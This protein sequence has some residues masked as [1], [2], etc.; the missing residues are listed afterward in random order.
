MNTSARIEELRQ[1]MISLG[2]S[3]GLSCPEVVAISE[4]L[5]KLIYEKM[6]DLRNG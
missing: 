2:L 1:E 3:K 4:Q 5:D 6:E